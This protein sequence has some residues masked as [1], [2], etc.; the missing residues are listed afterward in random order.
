[1]APGSV[2]PTARADSNERNTSAILGLYVWK[3]SESL[4]LSLIIRSIS[5][6]LQVQT[7]CRYNTPANYS[8]DFKDSLIY[9]RTSPPLLFP[10]RKDAVPSCFH[11]DVVQTHQYS[12]LVQF[13]ARS[14][15]LTSQSVHWQHF[16][17]YTRV[18]CPGYTDS[19][20]LTLPVFQQRSPLCV[21]QSPIEVVSS[22]PFLSSQTFQEA[23]DQE[24]TPLACTSGTLHPTRVP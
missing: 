12:D 14:L 22:E 2:F 10:A 11:S 8:A 1:M 7:T 24:T 17:N 5:I 3:R 23:N 18:I 13:S 19:V 4:D 21:A 20:T 15:V 16:F 6:F 9:S